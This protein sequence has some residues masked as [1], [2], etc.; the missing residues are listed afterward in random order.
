MSTAVAI[1]SDLIAYGGASFEWCSCLQMIQHC[2]PLKQQAKVTLPFAAQAAGAYVCGLP[3]A[4]DAVEGTPHAPAKDLY[5]L[6]LIAAHVKMCS[7]SAAGLCSS[8]RQIAGSAQSAAALQTAPTA[9]TVDWR[10]CRGVSQRQ[11]CATLPDM[12]GM[13]LLAGFTCKCSWGHKRG[14]ITLSHRICS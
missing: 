13:L 1:A 2:L 14:R 12:Q 9:A 10:K 3:T 5:L 7:S 6:V 8:Q 11:A 4:L